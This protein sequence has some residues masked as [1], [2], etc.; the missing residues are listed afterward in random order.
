MDNTK[1]HPSIVPSEDHIYATYFVRSDRPI[2]EIAANFS[3]FQTLGYEDF[4]GFNLNVDQNVINTYRA[5]VASIDPTES[6]QTGH[7]SIAFPIKIFPESV[8]LSQIISV[9]AGDL[10]AM[11]EAL[12]LR[13]SNVKFPKDFLKRFSG[14]NFGIEG[15]RKL[16]NVF[17]RPILCVIVRPNIGCNLEEFSKICYDAALGGAD[18]IKDD[19]K[20]FDIDICKLKDRI[21]RVNE[22]LEKAYKSTNK[23]T[24]YIVNLTGPIS[25]IIKL[26]EELD[27]DAIRMAMLNIFTIGFEGVDYI[28]NHLNTRIPFHAH[29]CLHA[30][31]TRCRCHGIRLNVLTLFARLIGIDVFSFGCLGG[32]LETDMSEMNNSIKSATVELGHIKPMLPAISHGITIGNL[33]KNIRNFGN[34]LFIKA[35]EGIYGHPKGTKAGV[36]AFLQAIEIYSKKL[37][38]VNEIKKRKFW[39]S[40]Y[41]ELSQAIEK[42]DYH[43]I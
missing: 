39:K 35:A 42:W 41:K 33:E 17:E 38:L 7:F 23:K 19:E 4:T 9:I 25:N 5:E 8:G 2:D 27:K 37:N 28:I 21:L 26:F 3:L 30:S 43:K 13:L 36:K 31:F 1:F 16:V 12:N 20:L 32:L 15:M 10:F 22:V 29:Q 18:F 34:D 24:I 11:D 40:K 14:P 6:H